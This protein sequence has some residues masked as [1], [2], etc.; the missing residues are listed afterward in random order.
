MAKVDKLVY[1]AALGSNHHIINNKVLK[2]IRM[3]FRTVKVRNDHPDDESWIKEDLK[4]FCLAKRQNADVSLWN[5]VHTLNAT[6]DRSSA[7]IG[8]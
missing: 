6:S 3:T 1:K 2:E 8:C 5:R 4:A 7:L